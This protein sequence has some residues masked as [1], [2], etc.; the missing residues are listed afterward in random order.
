MTYL[1]QYYPQL[2]SGLFCTIILCKLASFL[3]R[4]K[5]LRDLG[6]GNISHYPH[7]DPLL[8]YDLHRLIEDSKRNHLNVSLIQHLHTTYGRGKTFQALT[9]GLK[10]LYTVEPRNI[11][12]IL[13]SE[14][15]SFGVESI[16]KAFN[17]PWIGAGI[18]MSDGPV[19]RNSRKI[20]KPLFGK[21]LFADPYRLEHHLSRL[22]ALIPRDGSTID[23]QP[24]FWR[25]YFDAATELIVGESADSLLPDSR[26]DVPGFLSLM[27][28]ALEG[29]QRRV[30]LAPILSF[31]PRDNAWTEACDKIHSFFDRYIDRALAEQKKSSQCREHATSQRN[32][33]STSILHE[34]VEVSQDRRFIRDQLL[35]LFLPFHNASPIGIADLFFQVARAP[36][37]WTRMREEVQ[38]VGDVPLTFEL[39]KSMRYIQSVIK[40]S[41]RLLAPLDRILRHCSHDSVLPVG[42]GPSGSEPVLI[43]KNTLV[44]IRTSVLHREPSFWGPDAEDFR[45]ERWLDHTLRPKWEF[46]PFGGGARNCPAQQ[47]IMAQYALILAKFVLEFET[48]ENRDDVLEFVDEYKFSKRSARGVQVAFT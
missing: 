25:L 7:K 22:L 24:L 12:T 2:L 16:R 27:E 15:Q 18:V 43:Q 38:S 20:L 29:V 45:P 23:M 8:G 39:L 17:D 35:S 10:T 1:N 47:M 46:L 26:M 36:G 3:R 21:T 11:Q 40:E 42:G 44:E 13:T 14:F 30:T 32:S 4:R 48:I 34:L 41:L 19:W 9:W 6:C 37:V 28:R 31:V 33:R 5:R